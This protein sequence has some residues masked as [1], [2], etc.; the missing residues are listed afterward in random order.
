MYVHL[1]RIN[2]AR[3]WTR[4]FIFMIEAL[5]I[6]HNININNFVSKF[7]L[8]NNKNLTSFETKINK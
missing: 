1:K 6:F 8:N 7:V 2:H 5:D 3:G 4:V